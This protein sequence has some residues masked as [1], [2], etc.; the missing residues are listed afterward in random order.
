[1]SQV[2]RQGNGTGVLDQFLASSGDKQRRVSA[3]VIVFQREDASPP[4]VLGRV[5]VFPNRECV[6]IRRVAGGTTFQETLL[7]G[8]TSGPDSE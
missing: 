8:R 4:V 5:Q 3:L 6:C 1:M 2:T 7:P